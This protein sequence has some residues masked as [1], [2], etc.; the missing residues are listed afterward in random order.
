MNSVTQWSLEQDLE[1]IL[2]TTEEVF[3][4][5]KGARIFI[6]GGTG[7]IGSWLLESLRHADMRLCL[8]IKLT[9]LTRDVAA[10]KLKAPHLA[11]YE[12]FN[13]VEGEVASFTSPEG[14]FTHVIHAATDASADLNANNPIGMFD[15]VMP[16]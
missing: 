14:S 7:F 11:E 8:G 10:F 15:T 3:L 2:S 12:A 13:F 4:S 5:L 6:T 16:Q 9:V 1:F